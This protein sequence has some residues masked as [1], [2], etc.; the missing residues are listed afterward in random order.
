MPIS[1]PEAKEKIKNLIEKYEQVKESRQTKTYNEANTRKDFIMP[2]F[3]ALGWDIHNEL[4]KREV[5]EEAA[6]I[7]GRVDYSFRINNIPQ[8]LLEAKALKINLE[9]PEWA[10]QAVNYGWNKG[11]PWVVLS[12][13]EKLKLFNSD[14]KVDK[15]KPNLEFS[16]QDYIKRFDH[17]WL[18]SKEASKTN[19]LDKLLSQFGIT[20]K[21]VDVN[22]KLAEDLIRWRNILTK[23]LSQWNDEVSV[24]EIEEAVQRILDR[25]IFIRVVEDREIEDKILWQTFQKWE[26]NNRQPNNFI[27]ALVPVFRDFDKKYNSNLFLPHLCEKLET[28]GEPFKEIISELYGNRETGVK[29]RFDAIGADV[30]GGVYEQYLGH[31]Q[32][33]EGDR[34][35]RKKQG[36]YY[37]PAYIVD[38]IVQQT[39]G[40]VLKEKSLMEIENIKVLDPTCGSGSFLIKAFDSLDQKLA[41]LRVQKSSGQKAA[42]RK[43]NIL[44]NNI[45]GVDLDSQAIEI[46]RLNLLLRALEPDIKL[47]LLD[48]IKVGNSLISGEEKQLKKYFG[49]DYQ[50]KK[51][52]NW[53]EEFKEVFDQSGFDV[54][55]GNPPWG[56][57]LSD[58]EKLYFKNYYTSARG[59][60]DTFILFIEKASN[61]LRNGGYLG[62]ILP[63]IILLK[64]YPAIRKHILD[65]FIIKTAVHSGMV[66]ENVNLD[67]TILIL[68]KETDKKIRSK[69]IIEVTKNVTNFEAQQWE[70]SK[71]KQQLFEE[72]ENYKF[73]LY[74]TSENIKLKNKLDKL[75]IP[76]NIIGEAHEGIHSGNIRSKLFIDS[77]INHN[78]KKLLFR[79]DEVFPYLIKWGGKY[80]DYDTSIIN[81][82]KG[83]YANLGKKEYF[84]K[85]KI[86]I[87]RTGDKITAAL[88]ENHFYASNNLFVFQNTKMKKYDPRYILSLLNS[89]LMTWYFLTIQPRKGKLFAE[90]KIVHLNQ[91][92]IRKINFLVSS[93]KYKHDNL[94][95]LTNKMLKLNESL[96]KCAEDSDKHRDTKAEI[97]KIDKQIDQT[98]Y[99]LFN[100]T[101]EEIG[102]VEGN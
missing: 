67:S 100:L 96:Q 33:R 17:L 54:I 49:K 77:E 43:Y 2:L 20:A 69:N 11:I 80:V 53:D 101:S 45:Y 6:A 35:K 94:V 97:E 24:P 51:P 46:A 62:F 3:Q 5:V 72:N 90:V 58:E 42:F 84:E 16:Y 68:K 52:F 13:F 76:L 55:I 89:R 12:N 48:N 98:V 14:W 65:N 40:E 61:L 39:L 38:Y 99:K 82:N 86:L 27:E 91:F 32:Q 93:E 21:R 10:D 15:P 9:K 87:R 57:T 63:D 4:T 95:K 56:A 22:E 88:D 59:I 8:F 37:T 28:E 50:D 81:K 36:I 83:E 19:E 30:L 75:S 23:N 102:I 70:K 41:E 25:L 31:V 85:P 64:N 26:A 7:K 73:N 1:K 18:L 66:F 34:S 78:S 71:I 60:I 47:P 74:L 79:G 29:Y 92:P 44:K